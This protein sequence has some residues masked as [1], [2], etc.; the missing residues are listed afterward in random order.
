MRRTKLSLLIALAIVATSGCAP[1]KEG[2]SKAVL[3]EYD[4]VMNFK[5]YEFKNS[6]VVNTPTGVQD[7]K[8]IHANSSEYNGTWLT[9]V[10]CKI[11]NTESKA[12]TFSYD[13]SKFYVEHDGT[14]HYG[15]TLA[16]YTFTFAGSFSDQVATPAMADGIRLKLREETQL[17]GDKELILPKQVFPANFRFTIFVTAKF[18][19]V[20][21]SL[22]PKLRMDTTHPHVMVP[23]NQPPQLYGSGNPWNEVT[24]SMLPTTCRPPA[25]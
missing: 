1:L 9:F 8:K 2:L 17:G 6:F 5:G 20:D 23:R 18:K 22:F 16:P 19:G 25:N 24:A 13:V 11:T 21:A 12:E 10:I 7:V 3:V 14:K 15:G 4:Q